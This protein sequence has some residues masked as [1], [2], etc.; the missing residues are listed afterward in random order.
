MASPDFAKEWTVITDAPFITIGIIVAVAGGVWAFVNWMPTQEVQ[1]AKAETDAWRA[2]W[3]LLQDKLAGIEQKN[4]ML[5]RTVER[6]DKQIKQRAPIDTLSTTSA[7][8]QGLSQGLSAANSDLERWAKGVASLS[9]D[10]PFP[11][12]VRSRLR[13]KD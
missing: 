8:L 4:S 6:L 12:I 9:D 3:E 11:V 7:S 10:H 1:G 13:A 5:M 2:R